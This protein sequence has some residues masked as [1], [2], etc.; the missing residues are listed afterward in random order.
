MRMSLTSL[1]HF[2]LT[3][4]LFASAGPRLAAAEL[5][6]DLE[7]GRAGGESLRLDASV[8][9]GAG[10]FPVVMI[11]HGGGWGSGD[12]QKDITVL[13]EPLTR[14]GYT[15]FSI[16]YRLAPTN[17]WPACFEDVQTAIR[18][19]KAHAAEYKGDPRRLALIGYSAGGQLVCQA[20]VLATNDTRVQAVIGFAP[21]TDLVADTERRGGLSKSLQAL[22]DREEKVDDQVNTL[23]K[24]MSPINYVKPGLPPFLLIHGTV[25]KSVPYEQS[26]NFQARLKENGVPCEIVTVTNA[27]H[28]IMSWEKI[29]TSYKEKMTD[30]LKRTLVQP[31]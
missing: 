18:W 14:A 28:N 22:L 21:P 3:F 27:P 25:D 17:R 31:R 5:K 4:L 20:A 10:P 9:D 24:Q 1:S 26:L 29:D 16:N 19:V 8:P 15:W 6:T 30:W 23:L 12:K 11:V 13:F 7:Y 2:C